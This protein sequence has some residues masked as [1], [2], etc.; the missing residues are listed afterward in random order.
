MMLSKRSGTGNII[1]ILQDSV[2]STTSTSR[3]TFERQ[4]RNKFNELC[5]LPAGW[6]GYR[7]GPVPFGTANFAFDLTQKIAAI[8]DSFPNI[9][10]T[11]GGDI[12]AEWEIDGGVVELIFHGPL[13]ASVYVED[14]GQSEERELG[15]DFTFVEEW[16]SNLK[17]KRTLDEAAAA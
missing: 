9:F 4:I 17:A 8:A 6:D 5:A 3:R 13:K 7:S 14:D 11:S 2:A 12:Q 16:I 1:Y 15:S 10:P